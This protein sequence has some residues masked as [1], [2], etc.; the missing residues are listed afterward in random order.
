MR[1]SL[2]RNRRRRRKEREGVFGL[3]EALRMN[4]SKFILIF[5][6]DTEH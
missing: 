1:G 2:F 4:G 5:L 3:S 6:Q